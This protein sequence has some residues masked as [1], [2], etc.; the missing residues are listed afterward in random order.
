MRKYMSIV[1]T[2]IT[3]ASLLLYFM[4]VSEGGIYNS[5]II[6][7]MIIALLLGIGEV[8]AT[9]KIK[10]ILVL[11]KVVAMSV[12]FGFFATGN[13]VVLSFVDFIFGIDFWGNA[14]LI[15]QILKVGISMLLGILLSV[16]MCFFTQDQL[17]K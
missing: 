1:V 4:Y 10:N 12:A 17:E 6:V 11:A 5:L 9:Y 3:L 15:P 2:F 8:V 7:P 14:D 13:D 16:I